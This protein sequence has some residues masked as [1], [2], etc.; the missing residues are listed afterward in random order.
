MKLETNAQ[1]VRLDAIA[2]AECFS[3]GDYYFMRVNRGGFLGDK[4]IT[5][6]NLI[7]GE[8]FSFDFTRLVKPERLKIVSDI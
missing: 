1:L 7:N 2:D 6:I 5:A 8:L 3:C 4:P